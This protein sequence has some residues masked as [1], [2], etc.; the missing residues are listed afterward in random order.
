MH[1]IDFAGVFF[2]IVN[3]VG[4][5]V[6]LAMSSFLIDVMC[7]DESLVRFVV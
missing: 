6:L 5:T 2:F 3:V 7:W 4:F 1:F